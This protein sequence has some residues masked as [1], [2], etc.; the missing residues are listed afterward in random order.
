MLQDV[1]QC[2]ILCYRASV[3]DS[4]HATACSSLPVPDYML[5]G[6]FQCLMAS[7]LQGV[8]V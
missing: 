8:H 7:M 4:N 3:S 1:C 5:Q 6:A 2:L